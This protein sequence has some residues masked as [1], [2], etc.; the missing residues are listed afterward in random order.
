M[1]EAE[2]RPEVQS[3]ALDVKTAIAIEQALMA[4]PR[5]HGAEAQVPQV[6]FAHRWWPACHG[7]S[8]RKQS[9]RCRSI[10]ASPR[11]LL[12]SATALWYLRGMVC[13]TSFNVCSVR[14]SLSCG[15]AGTGAGREYF[16]MRTETAIARTA[17]MPA[18]MRQSKRLLKPC[19]LAVF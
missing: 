1:I 16:T 14:K 8:M 9:R 10:T 19:G 6:L 15:A 13:S 11:C 2:G 18:I 17:A 5:N 3:A 12:V 7:D 4:L